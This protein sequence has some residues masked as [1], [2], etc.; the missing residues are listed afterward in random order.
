MNETGEAVFTSLL[1]ALP[2]QR[3]ELRRLR[4]AF[5]RTHPLTASG[6]ED[7]ERLHVLLHKLNDRGVLRLPARRPDN[8]EMDVAPPLPLFVTVTRERK[9]APKPWLDELWPPELHW[10]KGLRTLSDDQFAFLLRVRELLTSGGHSELA[11]VKLRS[12]QLT[13]HEKRLE[14]YARGALFAPGRLSFEGLGCALMPYLTLERLR[15]GTLAL[16]F[17]NKD[18]FVLALQTLSGVTSPYAVVAYGAGNASSRNLSW[19]VQQGVTE[20]EYV[21]D[22]D[23]AGLEIGARLALEAARLGLAFRPASHLHRRMLRA[24]RTWQAPGKPQHPEA[25][26]LA[27]LALEVASRVGEAL[28]TGLRASE[29]CLSAHDLTVSREA[30]ENSPPDGGGGG[31]S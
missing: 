31:Q 1:R 20:V 6:A 10:V 30:Q 24:A 9:E 11:P 7:R 13:G 21:G 14:T 4:E 19:L 27:W 17:E 28:A 5:Y 2:R 18:P 15:P 3:V 8:W 22:L 29:E 23:G 12:L 16:M 26:A 25:H